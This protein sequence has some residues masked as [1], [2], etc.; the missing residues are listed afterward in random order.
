MPSCK[1]AVLVAG[2]CIVNYFFIQL[3]DFS[4]QIVYA[5][6][7][8]Y[9]RLDVVIP[10]VI[11]VSACSLINFWNHANVNVGHSLLTASMG[12]RIAKV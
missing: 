2:L 8:V 12:H 11:N 3:P 4:G 7:I 10:H 5:V 9:L 1:Y 6:L